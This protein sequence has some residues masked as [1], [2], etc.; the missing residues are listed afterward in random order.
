MQQLSADRSLPFVSGGGCGS[1]RRTSPDSL[2]EGPSPIGRLPAVEGRVGFRIR[3]YRKTAAWEVDLKV[4]LPDGRRYHERRKSPVS[5]KA[6]TR[7]WAEARE[8]FLIEHGSTPVLARDVPTLEDFVEKFIEGYSQ[9]SRLKHSTIVTQRSIIRTHLVPAF[10][11]LRLDEITNERV[12]RL[13]GTLTDLDEKTVNNIVGVLTR[14]TRIALDWG[15]I[16]HLPFKV[17]PLKSLTEEM[18][19]LE[20]HEFERAV[21]AA[22]EV[23][24]A[25]KVITLLGGE[26]GFR[27]G[28]IIALKREDVDFKRGD[29]IVRRSIWC[30]VEDSP[31]GNRIR[32]VPMTKRLLA[33]LNAQVKAVPGA[34]ILD[35]P[36]RFE[37]NMKALKS[38][39]DTMKVVQ[40]AAGLEVTGNVHILRHSFCAR[41]AMRGRS[42]LEIKE[43]A[44]HANL[45]TTMRYQ[46]LSPKVLNNA[47]ASLEQ[48][49]DLGEEQEKEK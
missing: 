26:A 3:R 12:H 25:A 48:P 47:V 1:G 36:D 22:D 4:R 35:L 19:F 8:R 30:G 7:R 20:D 43:L 42:A 21:C 24:L 17:R 5:G 31:K 2:S 39:R 13:R 27:V 49:L 10:G 46:H 29:L 28:E 38:I 37:P 23:G 40:R 45:S 15:L 11:K 32:R 33:A 18:K 44:G 9:A 16:E 14:M 6:A 41:L 34:Y